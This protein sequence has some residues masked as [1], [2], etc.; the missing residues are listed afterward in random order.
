MDEDRFQ[1]KMLRVNAC[2]SPPSL[3][4]R[5]ARLKVQFAAAMFCAVALVMY[6]SFALIDARHE[7][8]AAR[9]DFKSAA[10]LGVMP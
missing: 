1:S 5:H 2:G 7:L 8:R 10:V 9:G 3:A 4:F 6:L